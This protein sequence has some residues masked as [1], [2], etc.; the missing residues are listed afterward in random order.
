M[1]KAAR[2]KMLYQELHVMSIAQYFS[3]VAAAAGASFDVVVAADVLAYVG[4]LR[5]TFQQV[6]LCLCVRIYCMYCMC[7]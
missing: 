4:E 1:V 2:K 3:E 5:P 6:G 7:E